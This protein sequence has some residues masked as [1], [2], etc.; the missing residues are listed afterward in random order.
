MMF[1]VEKY[2]PLLSPMYNESHRFYHSI[3]HVHGLT[4][5][6]KSNFYKSLVKPEIKFSILS[7]EDKLNNFLMTV[8]WFH[9]CYY[10]P[11]LGSP[12]NEEL[13]ATIFN[14]LT[15][16]DCTLSEDNRELITDTIMFT[17]KH[18]DDLVRSPQPFTPINESLLFMDL[19]MYGFSDFDEFTYGNRL[20]EQEYYKTSKAEFKKSRIKF[21]ELLLNKPRIYYTFNDEVEYAARENIKEFLD[22]PVWN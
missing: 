20:I 2:I 14:S 22:Y 15:E 12:I 9:D 11:Y 13:S 4:K 5:L 18:L 1:I 19:D 16:S 10:D 7:S 21:F 6:I 3:K 17:S 8:A